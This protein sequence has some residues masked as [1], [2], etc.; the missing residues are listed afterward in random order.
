MVH[1][2]MHPQISNLLSESTAY[3]DRTVNTA[4]QGYY[5]SGCRAT[6]QAEKGGAPII[7]W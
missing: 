6:R 4:P 1:F 2:E 5:D 3:I 7:V